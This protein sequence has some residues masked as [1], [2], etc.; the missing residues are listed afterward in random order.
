MVMSAC[1][2]VIGTA[3]VYANQ[4]FTLDRMDKCHCTVL[5]KN[6][7]SVVTGPLL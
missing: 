4:I 5:D 3:F 1:R 7:V 6:G 2:S